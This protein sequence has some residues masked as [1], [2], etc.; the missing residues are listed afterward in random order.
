MQQQRFAIPTANM[1]YRGYGGGRGGGRFNYGG[2]SSFVTGGAN[3]MG[4]AGAGGGTGGGFVYGSRQAGPSPST[5]PFYGGGGTASAQAVP[6][7][8][9]PSDNLFGRR[10][11]SGGRPVNAQVLAGYRRVFFFFFV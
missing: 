6:G 10:F 3:A 9:N 7:T 1:A 4:H 5:A 8:M 11:V 2:S